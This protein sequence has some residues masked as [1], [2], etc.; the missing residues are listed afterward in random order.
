MGMAVFQ[1]N[2]IDRG[3]ILARGL[4]IPVAAFEIGPQIWGHILNPKKEQY[5]LFVSRYAFP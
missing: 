1:Y 2:F 4:R 3:P 5:F